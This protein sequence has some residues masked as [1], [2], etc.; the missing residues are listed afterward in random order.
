M[1]DES[2][3]RLRVVTNASVNALPASVHLRRAADLPGVE[4]RDI[5]RWSD[6]WRCCCVGFEFLLSRSF[7]G[8]VVAG[9]VRGELSPGLLLCCYP[10]EVYSTPR[11]EQVGSGRS[12]I[13]DAATLFENLS[14]HGI[15][16]ENFALRPLARP[17]ARLA[18]ALERAFA[19]FDANATALER[20]E[21]FASFI[22]AAATELVERSAGPALASAARAG[23]RLREWRHF[24][25]GEPPDLKALCAARGRSRF[26]ALR[27]FKR[28][29][30]LPPHAYQLCVKIGLAQRA[31]LAGASP[32]AVAAELGFVDQSH[33]SRHF[34]RLVGLT[35]AAYASAR[36]RDGLTVLSA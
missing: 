25:A 33:F 11:V 32:A 2:C 12:L 14:A 28:C 8:E 16:A 22:A 26:Q 23:I 13:V 31:L 20:Q 4:V 5:E 27:A 7:R 18:R 10:G 35:P 15:T 9:G 21:S 6:Q 1:K 17:S 30:G 34:K 19:S 24:E 3:S 29:Y 36:S